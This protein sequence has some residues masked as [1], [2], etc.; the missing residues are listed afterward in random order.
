MSRRSA[1]LSG[2]NGSTSYSTTRLTWAAWPAYTIR[3]TPRTGSRGSGRC[4]PPSTVRPTASCVTT[5]RVAPGSTPLIGSTPKASRYCSARTAPRSN[6]RLRPGEGCG[7]A[8]SPDRRVCERVQGPTPNAAGH[9]RDPVL[10]SHEHVSGVLC[11]SDGIQP[12]RARPLDAQPP[13]RG[14][15][16]RPR[17][18]PLRPAAP[19]TCDRLAPRAAAHGRPWPE[20]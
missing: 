3:C 15:A 19:G 20:P 18:K 5:G 7:P 6:G 1:A 9:T 10:L 2:N 17:R 12:A 11:W 8:P 4:T 13:A 16:C 14:A